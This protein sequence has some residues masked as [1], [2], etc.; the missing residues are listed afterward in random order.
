MKRVKAFLNYGR[1]LARCPKHRGGVMDVDPEKAEFICPVCYPKIIA[2]LPV[3]RGIG[4]EYVPDVS[5]RRTA[6]KQARDNND[7]FAVVFPKSLN[8]FMKQFAKK[9]VTEINWTPED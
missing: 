6:E 4:F 5:A 9:Q 7:V 1:W 8:K 3:K 2:V